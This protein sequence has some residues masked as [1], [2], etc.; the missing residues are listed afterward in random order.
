MCQKEIYKGFAGVGAEME[1][2]GS[3]RGGGGRG[4]GGGGRGQLVEN[5]VFVVGCLCRKVWVRAATN[6]STQAK[7]AGLKKKTFFVFVLLRRVTLSS[8][9]VLL[10][11]LI[12]CLV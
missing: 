8:S 6:G 4:L 3:G 12:C 11:D 5:F 9:C 2:V 1:A 7:K 10:H